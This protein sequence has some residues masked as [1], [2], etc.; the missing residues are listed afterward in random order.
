[1][2]IIQY[3]AKRNALVVTKGHP[4]ER[5]PFH[6]IFESFADIASSAVEQPA[7]SVFF[8]VEAARDIDAFVL[9]DMPGVEFRP[10]EL[11]ALHAPSPD[12]RERFLAL[13]EEGQGFVFLHHAIAGW[14]AWDEYAEI[15]GGRF[16]Y[17]PGDL[18][19]RPHPDSGYR[20]DVKHTVT[21]VDPAHPVVAGLPA[22]FEMEDELYLCPVFESDVVPLLRSNASFDQAEFSSAAE[23]VRGRMFSS[24]GWGPETGS[25]LVGWVKHYGRSPIVYLAGGDGPSSYSDVNFRRLIENAIRWVATDEAHAWARD[26][27]T[28]TNRAGRD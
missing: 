7:A 3:G 1:M 26:R 13:L 4:F 15:I 2:S 12:V 20:L 28:R 6:A 17:R 23:A 25:N 8:D 19:G 9:Y 10:G 14:P 18:R 11:P 27:A 21:V 16:L 22:S 5:D 24:E